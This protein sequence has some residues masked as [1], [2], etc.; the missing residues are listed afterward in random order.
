MT[1]IYINAALDSNE[2]ARD[3]VNNH[4]GD[5]VMAFLLQV[6]ELMADCQFTESLRDKL[7]EALE[8]EEAPNGADD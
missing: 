6:D 5:E 4:H 2:L 8:R 7:T 1:D 3:L